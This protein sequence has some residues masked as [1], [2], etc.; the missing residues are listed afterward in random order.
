MFNCGNCAGKIILTRG[1]SA[2]AKHKYDIVFNT[3]NSLDLLS[4]QKAQVT[5]AFSKADTIEIL[6]KGNGVFAGSAQKFADL[7]CRESFSGVYGSGKGFAHFTFKIGVEIQI[8]GDSHQAPLGCCQANKL[9]QS[10]LF[11]GD[12]SLKLG[13]SG[14]P[15]ARLKIDFHQLFEQF[16]LLRQQLRTAT[17]QCDFFIGEDDLVRVG[18]RSQNRVEN[19]LAHARIFMEIRKMAAQP[20]AFDVCLQWVLGMK[21]F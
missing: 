7:A 12:L 2:G 18:Q 6:A 13:Q 8:K 11:A 4:L 3:I 20:S 1:T 9:G 15:I 5:L 16:L 17:F 10:G 19:R 14:R 21:L